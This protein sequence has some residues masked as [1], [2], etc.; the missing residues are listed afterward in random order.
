MA[1]EFYFRP[2]NPISVTINYHA[3]SYQTYQAIKEVLRQTIKTE[4]KL[5]HWLIIPGTIMWR[6]DTNETTTK[7]RPINK[8]TYFNSCVYIYAAD[9]NIISRVEEKSYTCAIDGVPLNSDTASS[10]APTMLTKYYGDVK[11][12]K[13]L[14]TIEGLKI[15]LEICLEHNINNSSLGIHNGLI[16]RLKTPPLSM[17]QLKTARIKPRVKTARIKPRKIYFWHTLTQVSI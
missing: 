7:R 2:E 15:G 4:F 11:I 14:F 5:N 12:K 16:I 6:L 13:H 1:P 17:K 10:N 8:P 3:Y 9:G